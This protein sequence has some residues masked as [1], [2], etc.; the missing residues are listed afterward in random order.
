MH[1]FTVSANEPATLLCGYEARPWQDCAVVDERNL[2]PGE[3]TLFVNATDAYGNVS[4]A[5]RTFTLL[6]A[7]SANTQVSVPSSITQNAPRS[8]GLPVTFTADEQTALARLRIFRVVD[9]DGCPPCR[10][11][12]GGGQRRPSTPIG[13]RATRGTCGW[14]Y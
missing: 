4:E 10:W 5:S 13:R 2:G 12:H 7:Q 14:M 1:T 8:G 6:L 3:H 11:L 9:A